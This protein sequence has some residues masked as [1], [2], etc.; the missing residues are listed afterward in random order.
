MAMTVTATQG[1]TTTPGIDL[2][3]LLFSGAQTP[4]AIAAGGKT[5]TK[6]F[7]ANGALQLAITPNA[8]GSLVVGSMNNGV[9]TAFTML[10]STTLKAGVA[11]ATQGNEY[12]IIV[13]AAT[14]TAA[15]PVTLGAS[16]PT[17]AE[18]QIALAEILTAGSLA[19]SSA[20]A[21]ANASS[22][23]LTAI[24]TASFTPNPGDLVVP[25]VSCSGGNGGTQTV[26]L[27]NTGG[28]T[29]TNLVTANT[30]F[31]GVNAIWAAQ[32]PGA[33]RHPAWMVQR[34]PIGADDP[35]E[36]FYG[37]FV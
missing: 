4:A 10:A 17:T 23:T 31:Y 29:F 2:M 7:T 9:A 16:A 18:G 12:G 11:N 28:L 30:A 33:I 6:A 27:A 19:T 21:P 35:D 20:T 13:S 24:A 14:T 26:T 32:M 22:T 37:A 36:E 25:I 34:T 3:V 8:T 5:G 1:G 15:T